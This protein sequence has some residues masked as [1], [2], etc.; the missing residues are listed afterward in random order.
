[1]FENLEKYLTEIS[2]DIAPYVVVYDYIQYLKENS[3]LSVENVASYLMV[4]DQVYNYLNSRN[5]KLENVKPE[6][7]NI[8]DL[9]ETI[10]KRKYN[11]K[12]D[13]ILNNHQKKF[14][15]NYLSYLV[16]AQSRE[17]F[18]E[19]LSEIKKYT[20]ESAEEYR[21]GFQK[22]SYMYR[23][24]TDGIS[25]IKNISTTNITENVAKQFLDIL[26]LKGEIESV[27]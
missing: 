25:K 1:M 13:K 27:D 3:K 22:D 18:Q 12:Y 16:G 15:N 11:M 10:L 17:S 23:T 20:K 8:D 19:Y 14:M 21:S 4:E 26:K 24:I 2:F 7:E 6:L 9:F 5:K